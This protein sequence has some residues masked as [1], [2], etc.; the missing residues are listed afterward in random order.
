MFDR[1]GRRQLCI[2]TMIIAGCWH[3]FCVGKTNQIFF[4]YETDRNPNTRLFG[5]HRRIAADSS[6]MDIWFQQR[7]RGNLGAGNFRRC[8]NFVQF[9]YGLRNGYCKQN[10]Y[11]HP[12]N[13]RHGIRNFPCCFSM[14]VWLCRLYLGATCY[15]GC[16]GD[17]GCTNDED[18]PLHR[19][20]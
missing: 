16:A 9:A 10:L 19:A 15:C 2:V 11:A 12:F 13:T 17:S 14:V 4:V 1:D 5:L 18:K 7:R 8:Y 20:S 3:K 6:A